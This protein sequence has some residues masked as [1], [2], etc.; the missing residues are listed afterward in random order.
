MHPNRVDTPHM[1]TP[2]TV[3]PGWYPDGVTAGH[4]RWFDGVDW[5]A[6]TTPTAPPAQP[7]APATA[8]SGD[9]HPAF[10]QPYAAQQ[11]ATQPYATQQAYAGQGYTGQ[12][13]AGQ[14]YGAPASDNGPSTA[15]HWMLPV[16]RSWQSVT[17]GYLGLF[18]LAIWVLGPVSIGVGIWALVRANHGGHGRGRAIT[19]IVGGLLGTVILVA[20]AANGSV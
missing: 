1:T 19:G 5:T 6:H 10:A 13:Y 4:L 17:A 9:R 16:G 8:G 12:P 14:A 11:Y 2:A 3:P 20:F 7:A 18:S 15:M